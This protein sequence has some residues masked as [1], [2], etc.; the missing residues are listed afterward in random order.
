M[1]ITEI[2]RLAG[3][4][5]I[6]LTDAE[7][8]TFATEVSSILGY[9][10]E[11]HDIAGDAPPEKVAGALVNVMREDTDPHEPGRYT[12][13]LLSLAPGRKGQYVEVK[14]ILEN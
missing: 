10:S 7:A 3:L 14:K 9:V 13:D 11:I 12:E 8:A 2:H 6:E 1:E 4:A 5:R